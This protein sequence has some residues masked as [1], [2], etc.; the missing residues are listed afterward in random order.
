MGLKKYGLPYQGSKNRIAEDIVDFLPQGKRLVDLFG[1]GGAISHCAC[2]TRKYE[3]VL[4]NECVP[5]VAKAFQMAIN[6][7]FDNSFRWVS[8]EE[9]QELK[10][11]DPFVAFCYSFGY[12]LHTYS[13]GEEQEKLK[14]AMY[15]AKFENDWLLLHELGYN[16]SN[17]K[18][19]NK[20]DDNITR[21]HRWDA[22][23][24]LLTLKQIGKQKYCKVSVTCGGYLD[25]EYQEGDV[26][27]CDPPYENTRCDGYGESFD[28]QQFYDWVASR[29]YQ[30]FFSSY[31]ITDKRFPVV[32]EKDLIETFSHERNARKERIYSNREF[33]RENCIKY[34]FTFG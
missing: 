10:D 4:Y 6:G 7:E 28:S 14:K 33:T 15:Y 21:V 3:S 30:V 23:R 24:R 1:G 20:L 31:D 25:Y 29:P 19:L 2:M 11:I 8:S 13:H 17:L 32:W 16:Y 22:Y 5:L 9:F 34:N 12:A 26:V 27:Y 18:D